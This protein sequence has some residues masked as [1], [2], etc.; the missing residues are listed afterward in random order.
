MFPKRMMAIVFSVATVATSLSAARFDDKVR[1]DFFAGFAGDRAALDRGIAMSE[2]AIAADPSGSAEALAW[3]GSGVFFLAGLKFQQGDVPGGMELWTKGM[4]EMEKA[5][6]MAPDSPG[7]LIPRASAWFAASRA[8]PPDVAKPILAKALADYEHVYELQK[9]R[10]D[11]MGIHPRSELLFGLADGYFRSGDAA[12]AR[13]Y[14]EKL[15]ALGA[16]SGHLEQAKLFLA[17]DKYTVRGTGCVGC[18]VAK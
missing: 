11:T 15:A 2:Q 6:V 17:G 7:V 8:T 5:G 10:F 14:F 12:K 18:H 13:V 16:E 1:N 4:A 3:H 9:A